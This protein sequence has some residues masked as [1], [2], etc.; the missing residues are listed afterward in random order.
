MRR[1]TLTILGLCWVAVVLCTYY[2]HIWVLRS[3]LGSPLRAALTVLLTAQ[4]T[5]FC[6]LRVLGWKS[7]NWREAVPFQLCIGLAAISYSA[8]ALALLNAYRPT[9]VRWFI[10]AIF[11]LG[12]LFA[13]YIILYWYRING[14][15][16]RSA[17]QRKTAGVGKHRH[18]S[19]PLISV[20]AVGIA[21]IGAL[22]PEIEY[23]A[24]DYHLFLPQ[25]WLNAGH[26]VDVV[27]A[28]TS[29]YPL[30]WE[31]VFGCA[32]SMGGP[33]AAKLIHFS[34][35]LATAAVVYEMSRRYVPSV[36]PWMTV[37]FWVTIPT[38]M[39]EATT[40]YIDLALAFCV[41]LAVFSV[42]RYVETSKLQWLAMTV[43]TLG[44]AM[45]TKHLGVLVFAIAA[46]GMMLWLWYRDR[47]FWTSVLTLLP[48]CLAL[49]LP[50]PWYV[51]AWRASGNPVYPELYSVFGA[52]PPERINEEGY[53]SWALANDRISIGP[54]RS[55]ISYITLPWDVTTHARV[56]HG[57]LG[58]VFL[59]TLP[60][61][62]LIA[63]AR[64]R[65]ALIAL[66]WFAWVYFCVW[67]SPFLAR[68]V[69]YLL[70]I[71]PALALLG[72]AGYGRLSSLLR[73]SY[74]TFAP[75]LMNGLLLA[76][77]TLNLPLFITLHEEARADSWT[78]WIDAVIR[79]IPTDVVLRGEPEEF[80]LSRKIRSY[81]AWR[82]I[83]QNLPLT[84]RVLSFSEG[85]NY[86]S[87]RDRVPYYAVTVYPF[88]YAQVGHED[89]AIAGLRKLGFTHIL[90]DKRTLQ[91]L[92]RTVVIAE[93]T[94]M[95]KCYALEYEDQN[96]VLYRL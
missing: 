33:V 23:D 42:I 51:R 66:N 12:T 6:L 88:V 52:T 32:M 70:P 53:R 29:L 44:F 2:A 49:V 36:S 34:T 78:N 92:A 57:T 71:T 69:R 9:N 74:G 67:A 38:V 90:F 3:S 94:L 10:D 16:G 41:T 56:Y 8:L 25:V 20:I 87:Q 4:L 50:L 55:L 22:A 5:G 14:K 31:L 84:A 15:I 30:T 73:F 86:Y 47:R 83:N 27:W 76:T 63:R 82:F 46:C 19:W 21:L 64:R 35:M 79:S 37:A 26:P 18:W 80:Y 39:W 43:F 96:F 7:A 68:Q 45:A 17:G 95:Q 65:R 11:T 62:L 93:P 89:E 28:V 61:L 77:L 60:F 81:G 40:A 91:N 59:L 85:D 54:P 72:T 58:P 13:A 75:Q 24:L 48:L 1:H